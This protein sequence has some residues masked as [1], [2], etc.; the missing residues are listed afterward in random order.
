MCK[1]QPEKQS[2]ICKLM[3]FKRWNIVMAL[4]ITIPARVFCNIA[5]E[6]WALL[7]F[8]TLTA[9]ETPTENNFVCKEHSH[10]CSIYWHQNQ[11]FPYS[12][13]KVLK[14][15]DLL[16]QT[17]HNKG[18]WRGTISHHGNDTENEGAGTNGDRWKWASPCHYTSW[19]HHRLMGST[20]SKVYSNVPASFEMWPLHIAR[21]WFCTILSPQS[22]LPSVKN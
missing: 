15:T 11:M 7:L 21:S 1:F 10:R 18:R 22:S 3:K 2:C 6:V 17:I 12:E 4:T 9:G 16:D 14:S 19:H 5:P 13:R 20:D 8:L